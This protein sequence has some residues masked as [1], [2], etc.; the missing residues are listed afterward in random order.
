MTTT[1]RKWSG[2]IEATLAEELGGGK[3]K[4]L[5][6]LRKTLQIQADKAGAGELAFTEPALSTRDGKDYWQITGSEQRSKA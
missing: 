4:A 2:E 1:L 3:E 5:E 6:M